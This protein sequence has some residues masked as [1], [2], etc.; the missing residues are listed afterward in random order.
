MIDADELPSGWK[1]ARLS[2]PT[3]AVLNPKKSEIRGVSDDTFV[4]FVPMSAVDDG[5][6]TIARPDS[7]KLGAV[8]KGYTYFA[9]DDVIF[10][11][12][13]LCMEN[14]KCAIARGLRN[15]IGFGS[16]EFHVIRAGEK[17]L[18]EWLHLILCSQQ[19]RH[20]AENAMH[21]AAGQQRVPVDFLEQLEIPVPPLAEQR[22]LVARIEALTSRLEQAR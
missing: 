11:K 8:R 12:I 16:T 5:S 15:K 2:D 4:T 13:T 18:P 20:D 9:E 10:A 1:V 6:G 14:G 17:T 21:G 19:V 22:R 3:I 7:R